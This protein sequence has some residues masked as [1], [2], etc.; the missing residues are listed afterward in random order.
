[1]NGRLF[2]HEISLENVKKSVVIDYKKKFSS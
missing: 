2:L 1:M